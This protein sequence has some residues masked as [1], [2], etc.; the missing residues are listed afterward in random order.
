MG[1]PPKGSD[2]A[3]PRD[4]VEQILVYGE[5]VDVPGTDAKEVVYP[6]YRDVAARF[7]VSQSLIAEFAKKRNCL[8][9]RKQ[10]QK[11]TR[12]LSDQKL[13]EL[14]ADRISLGRDDAIRLVDKCLLEFDESVTEGRIRCESI[15]D[16]NTLLRLKSFLLGDADSRSE[17]I[18]GLTL[19][20]IQRRHKQML[21]TWDKA[22]PAM[23][24][25]PHLRVVDDTGPTDEFAEAS[26][27]E[28]RP[29][30]AGE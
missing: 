22:T 19:E 23:R 29:E 26:D 28:D 10:M 17:L 20:D 11:H 30:P 7:D 27:T 3:F 6:S 5:T 25:Y 9:R 12:E 18:D 15:S 16:L 8:V 13:A 1:R 2:P 21:E 24:G 14:R 4:L